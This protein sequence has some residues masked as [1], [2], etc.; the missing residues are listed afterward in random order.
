[1]H[2]HIYAPLKTRLQVRDV[3]TKVVA[4]ISRKG[5]V[6]HFIELKLLTRTRPPP[7][8]YPSLPCCGSEVT[9]TQRSYICVL[10]L[11]YVCPC[12]TI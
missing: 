4:R 1:M 11:L 6:R 10:I 3:K 12:T 9:S 8:L 7:D 2:V 5:G